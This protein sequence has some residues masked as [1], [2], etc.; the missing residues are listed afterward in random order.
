[1]AIT[2][3]RYAA[4]CEKIAIDKGRITDQSSPQPL[5]YDI[6]RCWRRAINATDF[7]CEGGWTEKELVMGELILT[8]IAYLRRKGCGNIEM[9]LKDTIERQ[10]AGK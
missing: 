10:R 8:T 2:L 9:L 1:M 5:L 7:N 4:L 3:N 6:S